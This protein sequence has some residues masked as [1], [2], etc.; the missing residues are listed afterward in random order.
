MKHL[1]AG[2]FT[3]KLNVFEGFA[4]I[5]VGIVFVVFP[6]LFRNMLFATLPLSIFAFGVLRLFQKLV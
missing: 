3:M 1:E 6:I 2:D 4:A 5:I